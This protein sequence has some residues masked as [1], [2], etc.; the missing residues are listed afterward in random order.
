MQDNKW[1]NWVLFIGLSV[2]WGSSFQ[3]MKTGMEALSAY[4]V[5]ALRMASA[6]IV[7]LPFFIRALRNIPK[8]KIGLIVWS[9]LLGNF[10]PS[11]L[12]CI[13]ETRIDS[14]LAGIL[15]ALTPLFTILVS[16]SFFQAKVSW[17]KWLGVSIGFIGLCLLFLSKGVPDLSYVSY[18][19]LVLVAT[20]CYGLNVNLVSRHLQGI[21]SIHIASAALGFLLLPALLTLFITGYFNH[22]FTATPVLFSTGASVVLGALGTALASILFYMLVKRAGVIFS[23]M[24]TYGIPFVALIWGFLAHEEITLLQIGCLGIIL[25]GVWVTNKKIKGA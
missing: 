21:D 18:S 12:F 5:A 14:A 24:V 17:N 4:Q 3:L 20:I 6:G 9:G 10:F 25:A 7:L 19:S 13:A 23:S 11:F 1:M 22:D 2:I 16:V 15:N 8:Q